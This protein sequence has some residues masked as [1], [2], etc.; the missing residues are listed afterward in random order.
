MAN[1]KSA[2]KRAR[3]AVARR[4]HNMSLRTAVRSAIKNAKKALAAGKQEDALKA[5]RASQRMIDRV[6][7]KGVLHR[8][9]GDRHK[10]RLA[11]ALKGMK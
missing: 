7:A 10:S 1:I 2:R 4:D 5:L 8:N 11:H 9:A 3:Q 6:V